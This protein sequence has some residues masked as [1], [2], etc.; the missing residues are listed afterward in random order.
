MA[1]TMMLVSVPVKYVVEMPGTAM[2]CAA[3]LW[4]PMAMAER[5]IRP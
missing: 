5:A 1:P 2:Y 4:M 3:A